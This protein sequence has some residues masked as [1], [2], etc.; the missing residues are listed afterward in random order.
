MNQINAYSQYRTNQISY[1]DKGKLVLMMYD[2]AIQF[3]THAKNKLL[4][5]DLGGMGLY[6]GKAQGVISE[7]SD[8]LN[9]EEG[10]D[11]SVSLDKLYAFVLKELLL[12]NIKKDPVALERLISILTKLR[13]AWAQIFAKE[14][15]KITPKE[16]VRERIACHL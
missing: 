1:A 2:G 4:K 7:L 15:S 9:K 12:A 16:E 6:L 10:G 3:I 5:K 13:E 8:K 11:I 14:A